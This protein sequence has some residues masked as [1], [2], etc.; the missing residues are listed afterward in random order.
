[1]LKHALRPDIKADLDRAVQILRSIGCSE[2]Y[3]FGS[4]TDERFTESSDLDLAVRGCPP[5]RF[6]SVLGR[7]MLELD[8]SVDLVDLDADEPFGQHL[9]THGRMIAIG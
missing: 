1:M 4:S 8:H 6:F 3:L 5:D 7:L 9:Q 2:I